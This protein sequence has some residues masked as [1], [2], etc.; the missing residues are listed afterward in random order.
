MYKVGDEVTVLS[1][2]SHGGQNRVGQRGLIKRVD[3]RDCTVNVHFS[4]KE[5]GWEDVWFLFSEVSLV[6]STNDAQITVEK[7]LD[8]LI[9]K[10]YTVSLSK[11]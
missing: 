10:G 1:G 11:Q 6:T 4:T 5:G 3:N 9:S 2:N 8:F 7:A